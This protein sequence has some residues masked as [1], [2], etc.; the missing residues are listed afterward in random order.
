MKI[1]RLLIKGVNL[2]LAGTLSLIGFA[3]CAKQGL[4]EY[5]TPNADYTVKGAVVNKATGKPIEGIRVAYSPE[6]YA[7]VMYGVITAP[8]TPKNHVLTNGKG[9]FK[10]TDNFFDLAGKVTIPV[11]VEDIDGEENGLFQSEY[12]EVDFS[13]AEHGGKSK[14]WYGGEYTITVKVE[15]TEIENQ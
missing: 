2:I 14:S 4:D 15:M 9:E 13:Q 5:G 3:G 10:L 11:F 7:V 8:Y 12:L 1:K 6:N